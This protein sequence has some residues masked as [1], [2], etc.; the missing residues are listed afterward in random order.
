MEK[1]QKQLYQEEGLLQK[2]IDFSAQN[3]QSIL[4]RFHL[5]LRKTKEIF[6]D[7]LKE[8]LFGDEELDEQL[9]DEIEELLLS[10][11]V[12]VPTSRRILDYLE[13]L[14]AKGEIK[15]KKQT[16]E[17]LQ[18]AVVRV[19]TRNQ[20][21]FGLQQGAANVLLFVGVNGVGKTTT[22]GKIACQL[23]EQNQKVLLAAGDT[24]RAAAIEQLT[25]W[26]QRIGVDIVAK[27]TGAD[28][29]ATIFEACEKASQEKYDCLLCD[30]SGRLHTNKNLM[31]ELV[32]I[33]KVVQKLAPKNHQTM[34]VLD[35][36][37]GQ[38]AVKQTKIFQE[39][40]NIDGL[41]ITKLDGS[42]KGGVIIGLANEF[43][44]PIYFLGLGEKKEE[45]Q[46][47]D[48]EIFVQALFS[49]GV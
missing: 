6:V 10:V 8:V 3:K 35:A 49:D 37:T 21:P 9:F 13:E 29:A 43:E 18:S 26:S 34:L 12:G 11:D 4:G 39:M 30:T 33:K 45:L 14:Y 17:K 48:P 15:T 36:N 1:E 5:G 44:L 27:Q 16:F 19:L 47:F 20:K 38:N 42:A 22:I 7:D 32:K 28:S 24:Y 2:K 31:D 40:I 46:I 23:K 41:I 25:V